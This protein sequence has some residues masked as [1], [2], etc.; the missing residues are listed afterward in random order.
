MFGLGFPSFR[1]MKV[2]QVDSLQSEV[3]SAYID[4]SFE[5]RRMEAVATQEVVSGHFEVFY[6]SFPER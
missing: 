5:E 1:I 3:L 4:L 6:E 2:Y